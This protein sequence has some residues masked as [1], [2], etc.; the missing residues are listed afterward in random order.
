MPVGRPGTLVIG[1]RAVARRRRLLRRSNLLDPTVSVE[2]TIDGR[3]RE[4]CWKP[5]MFI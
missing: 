5:G 2:G 3:Q 1:W 4:L